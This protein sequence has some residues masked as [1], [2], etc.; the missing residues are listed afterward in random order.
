VEVLVVAEQV[1]A[2]N[3]LVNI[4]LKNT[5]PFNMK[6]FLIVIIS[7]FVIISCDQTEKA[8][9]LVEEKTPDTPATKE[10]I[11][12]GDNANLDFL[13]KESFTGN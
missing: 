7:S 3:V 9:K 2:G 1:E 11:P 10:T 8:T 12:V 13:A 5:Y 4:K 6:Y